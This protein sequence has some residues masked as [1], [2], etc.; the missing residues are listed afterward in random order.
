MCLTWQNILYLNSSLFNEF[1]CKLGVFWYE[2]ARPTSA[3]KDPIYTRMSWIQRFFVRRAPKGSRSLKIFKISLTFRFDKLWHLSK[4]AHTGEISRILTVSN[5][6]KYIMIQQAV[7]DHHTQVQWD[8]TSSL[9]YNFY[10]QITQNS[11]NIFCV[12]VI[13]TIS[14]NYVLNHYSLKKIPI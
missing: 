8:S 4:S 1:V 14:N 6:K 5:K 10:V 11:R 12:G 9:T 2:W 3:K 7:T 13:F